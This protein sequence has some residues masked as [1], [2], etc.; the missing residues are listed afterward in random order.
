MLPHS[1]PHCRLSSKNPSGNGSGPRN[2]VDWAL[3]CAVEALPEPGHPFPKTA[4][5]LQRLTPDQDS[6]FAGD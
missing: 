6:P 5:D 1:Q 2:L 4:L 3:L